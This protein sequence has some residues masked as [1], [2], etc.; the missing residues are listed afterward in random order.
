MAEVEGAGYSGTSLVKKLGIKTGMALTVLNRPDHYWELLGDL[1]DGLRIDGDAP[2]DFIHI[3][4]TAR[5]ELE[6]ELPRLRGQIVQNGMIWVSW[7]KKAAKVATDVTEDVVREIAL[8]HGLVDVKV[9]A[10]DAVW[11]GLKLVIRVKERT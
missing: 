10:L 1:P 3:F 9:A 4:T 8:A 5:T 6:D 7:P 2:F 11:S